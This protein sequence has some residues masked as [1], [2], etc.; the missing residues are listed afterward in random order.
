M[1]KR[2]AVRAELSATEAIGVRFGAQ[3]IVAAGV[4]S[5]FLRSRP[6]I[7]HQ[8]I[9]GEGL[10]LEGLWSLHGDITRG[11]GGSQAFLG[12]GFRV[13]NAHALVLGQMTSAKAT[14]TRTQAVSHEAPT[15]WIDGL[16]WAGLRL[17][18]FRC[19]ARM[20]ALTTRFD[21][22]R[23]PISPRASKVALGGLPQGIAPE[24]LGGHR[25]P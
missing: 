10:R 21:D 16:A 22:G 6:A 9:G 1:G 12:Q 25:E 7:I 8:D 19:R 15:P 18:N 24:G 4:C 14:S 20:S 17:T 5:F 13:K 3:E 2:Y 23:I 11:A